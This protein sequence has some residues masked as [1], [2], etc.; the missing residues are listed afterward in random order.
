MIKFFNAGAYAPEVA[1]D[2]SA[3]LDLFVNSLSNSSQTI[4][5]GVHVEIPRGY[6]GLVLPRSSWGLK[7]FQLAN[8]CGVIDSDYRGEIILHRD[9]HPT[10]GHLHLKMGNKIAQ[11]VV[12][13]CMTAIHQCGSLG[14]LTVT[15]RGEGGFG[16]TGGA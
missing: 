7:G 14:E 6:V 4:G 2:G 16:S 5:T 10:K 11:L 12:V 3:G 15:E 9:L 8:T 13:P 1:T